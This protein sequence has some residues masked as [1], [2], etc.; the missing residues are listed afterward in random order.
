MTARLIASASTTLAL[1]N[2]TAACVGVASATPFVKARWPVLRIENADDYC[3]YDDQIV[4]ICVV[5]VFIGQLTRETSH[6]RQP[7]HRSPRSFHHN[8]NHTGI[9]PL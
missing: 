7:A 3:R 1:L 6:Y 4:I 8:C 9:V 2:P 5:R